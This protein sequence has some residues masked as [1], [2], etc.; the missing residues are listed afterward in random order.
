MPMNKLVVNSTISDSKTQTKDIRPSEIS[1]T[2]GL[3]EVTPM[4]ITYNEEANIERT[5]N[6]LTWAERVVVIDSFSTDKTID[7]LESYSNVDI[8]YNKFESFADQC[9][10]GLSKIE[11]TWVLSLDADYVL[12]IDFKE[13][14]DKYVSQGEY[15]SYF[16]SFNFCVFGKAL[17]ADNTTARKVLYKKA[18]A[19]YINVG[20][21]H[22]VQVEGESFNFKTKIRHDDRKSLSRWLKSQDR[23]LAVEAKKLKETA[24]KDLDTVD[25]IRKLKVFAPILIFFWCLFKK[26]LI[27]Q[28]WIGFY[29]T[30]QRTLVE[31]LLSIRLIEIE[32]FD[33]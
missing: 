11:S 33:T 10:F 12:S 20:H 19:Y 18:D 27:L 13:E 23:Y 9:N 8:Y 28:G 31:I 17:R 25:K 32:K 29:Y 26:G 7:I 22:R 4:I 15:N 24:F 30:L 3:S 5:L 6:Q 1:R 14:L 2:S 21:Q 16:A